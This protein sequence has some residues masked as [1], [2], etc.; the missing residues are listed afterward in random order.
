MATIVE[1]LQTQ[2][3]FVLLGAGY[4]MYQSSK[5]H[6]FFGNLGT[7]TK[8]GKNALICVCDEH[9]QIGWINADAVTVISVDG[10]S[11]HRLLSPQDGQ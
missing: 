1:H 8:G 4:G 9:A 5:P 10:D 11:P 2:Q 7:E 3:R 6:P